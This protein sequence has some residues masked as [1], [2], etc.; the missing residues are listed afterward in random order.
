MW[1]P[2]AYLPRVHRLSLIP[3]LLFSTAF[4]PAQDPGFELSRLASPERAQREAAEAELRS[5]DDTAQLRRLLTASQEQV[6]ELQLRLVRALGANPRLLPA[7]LE[8]MLGAETATRT[9]AKAV[10]RAHVQRFKSPPPRDPDALYPLPIEPVD[11]RGVRDLIDLVDR[12][13]LGAVHSLPLLLDP[14]LARPTSLARRPLELEG[15][16]LLRELLPNTRQQGGMLSPLQLL[17]CPEA[18]LVIGTSDELDFSGFVV[19]C[20]EQLRHEDASVRTR[21]A[22]ELGRAELGSFGSGFESLVQNGS[23]EEKRLAQLYFAARRG[24]GHRRAA[25]SGLASGWLEELR[26]AWSDPLRRSERLWLG[27]AL[28]S[29]LREAESSLPEW[30]QAGTPWSEDPVRLALLAEVPGELGVEALEARLLAE[31]PGRV[32]LLRR[33]RWASSP[34][35]MSQAAALW[36]RLHQP[37]LGDHEFA[38]TLHLL[39]ARAVAGLPSAEQLRPDELYR[40]RYERGTALAGYLRRRPFSERERALRWLA[41]AEELRPGDLGL[42]QV[43]RDW[44]RPPGMPVQANESL[45]RILLAL[46]HGEGPR[47]R[48]RTRQ[49]REAVL[50]QYQLLSRLLPGAEGLPRIEDEGLRARF[51]RAL[52]R[53]LVRLRLAIA[54]PPDRKRL[55]PWLVELLSNLQTRDIGQAAAALAL[56]ERSTLRVELALRLRGSDPALLRLIP[57]LLRLGAQ[58]PGELARC[59]LPPE[60]PLLQCP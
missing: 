36:A 16:W 8:S 3:A 5:L 31:G 54:T 20:A 34:L 4:L 12:C 35:S 56:R 13:A 58:R 22:L 33:L 2:H 53:A 51:R 41:N 27:H 32:A 57:E 46:G 18:S 44:R 28:R 48:P 45:G 40:A 47:L 52:G 1:G 39:E 15:C 21:A 25:D 50:E 10:L 6:P 11:V 23:D 30:F 60:D 49:V 43:R 26:R 55:G 17:L 59:P 7:L 29:L 9:A 19:R 37:E 42:L 24:R 38:A 14:R